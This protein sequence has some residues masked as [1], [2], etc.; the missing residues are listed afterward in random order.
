MSLGRDFYGSGGCYQGLAG[1]DASR[2]L[3]KGILFEESE[4]EAIKPLSQDEE[5][6]MCQ[7]LEH[8]Q[9]KYEYLGPLLRAGGG[10]EARDGGCEAWVGDD[11]TGCRWR[12]VGDNGST[13]SSAT[14]TSE[15]H[16][17]VTQSQPQIESKVN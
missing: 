14:A 10:L 13:A 17:V 9:H 11:G 15:S 8:Y 2:L 4:D 7:W 3:A 1:R 5:E 16:L 12:L 6:A